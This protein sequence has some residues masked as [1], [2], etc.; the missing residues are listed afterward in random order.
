MTGLRPDTTLAYKYNDDFR[1]TIP[2][3][4]TIPMTLSEN[5]YYSTAIGKIFHVIDGGN[6]PMSWEY[7]WLQG[8]GS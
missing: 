2:W 6:D 3:A 5:G 1:S 4:Y 8:G 7:S